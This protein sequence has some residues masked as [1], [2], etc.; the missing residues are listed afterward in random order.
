MTVMIR[1]PLMRTDAYHGTPTAP[2]PIT[3]PQRDGHAVL[4]WFNRGGITVERVMT[5]S[6]STYRTHAFRNLVHRCP[7]SLENPGLHAVCSRQGQTVHPDQLARIGLCERPYHPSA[8][9]SAVVAIAAC[10]SPDRQ[11]TQVCY[12][13][14]VST[15]VKVGVV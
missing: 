1:L 7:A 2:K 5:D 10:S 12:F 9:R 11:I 4:H 14:E 6:G 8:E 15:V 13:F 3:R